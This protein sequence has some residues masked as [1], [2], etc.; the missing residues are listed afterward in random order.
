MAAAIVT[1]S[2]QMASGGSYVG[3]IVARRLGLAY[4]DREVLQQAAQRLGVSAADVA[5]MEERSTT[6]WERVAHAL[7]FGAPEAPYVPPP[8]EAVYH[9][10]LLVVEHRIIREIAESRPAVIVGRG[11]GFILRDHPALLSVFLHAPQ[12]WRIERAQRTYHIPVGHEAHALVERADRDRSAFLRRLTGRDWTDA[13]RFDLCV[14]T[15]TLDL[16]LVADLI[17]RAAV[18]RLGLKDGGEP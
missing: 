4:F 5:L 10:D 11:A 9:E 1:I 6:L 15:S 3:Q 8:P 7:A 2:R 13:S 12:P 18:V 16:E 17:T 14:R